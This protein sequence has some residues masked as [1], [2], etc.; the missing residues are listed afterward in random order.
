MMNHLFSACCNICLFIIGSLFI[1]IYLHSQASC[2]NTANNN[3]LVSGYPI[4][5]ESPGAFALPSLTGYVMGTAIL[6]KEDPPVLFLQSDKRNIGTYLYYFLGFTS[7]G[8]PIYS[9]P[10]KLSLPFKETIDRRG[11]IFQD[12]N[13]KIW[14]IWQFGQSLVMAEFNKSK[15]CFEKEKKVHIKGLP[16][17]YKGSGISQL[18]NGKQLMLF[19]IANKKPEDEI[20]MKFDSLYYT[21]EGFWPVSI[22]Q[23]GVYGALFDDILE[24]DQINAV[25]LTDLKDIFF[26]YSSFTFYHNNDK[27]SY[28]IA[29]TRMG[30]ILTYQISTSPFYLEKKYIVDSNFN[31]LRS[32]TIHA[33]VGYVKY[34]MKEEGILVSG[35]GS[36]AYYKNT[37]KKDRKG[38]LIFNGPKPVMQENPVLYGGSLVVPEL[39][40]WD[41]D[42]VL[43]I[44]SGNSAGYILFFRNKG[45][46]IHPV[47]ASPEYLKAGGEI[48]HIQPG[49]REDIQGPG[50]ARWGYVCPTVIDWNSDGLPDILTGDSRGKFMVFINKGSKSNPELEVERPLY[51]KGMNIY[52]GWRVKPGVAKMG[53]SMAYVILDQDNELHLYWQIDEYNLEDKGKLKL[54]DGTYI[55]ANRRGGGQTGRIKIHLVDWDQDGVIDILVGTGRAQSIP[56]SQNGLPYNW[57]KKNEGGAV[58]FLKNVGTNEKPVFAYPKMLEYRGKEM[59]FGVHS[60]APTTSYIGESGTLNLVVGVEKGLY[61]FFDRKDISW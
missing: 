17:G 40:D 52:G 33:Y 48:I 31:L 9:Q 3:F 26:D 54:T 44:I 60:C 57:G 5:G 23:S 47:F 39:V 4:K 1:P 32:L 19:G 41:G 56:N 42:G 13:N 20:K 36:L 2:E 28:A 16:S 50:E 21:P 11:M 15:L 7:T 18:P 46:N 35:E 29:G 27:E 24:A 49:Y 38:N 61:M 58:L 30:N 34:N 14:G 37:G 51:C 45:S 25:K 8:N 6:N 53:D 10:I 43:D 22:P 55:K 59:L 12:K